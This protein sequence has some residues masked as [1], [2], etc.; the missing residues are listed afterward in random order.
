MAANLHREM[1]LKPLTKAS[2]RWMAGETAD[3]LLRAIGFSISRPSYLPR[4][5]PRRLGHRRRL[6]A[7]PYHPS[8]RPW[9]H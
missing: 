1:P 6:P 7:Q 2:A 5:Q 9:P 4:G 8:G 3:G